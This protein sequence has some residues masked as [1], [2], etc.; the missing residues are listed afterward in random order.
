M[1]WYTTSIL[2]PIADSLTRPIIFYAGTV[3]LLTLI[4]ASL[5]LACLHVYSV[6]SSSFVLAIAAFA[7]S[8]WIAQASVWTVCEFSGGTL[9]TTD[10]I[11]IPQ[12]CPQFVFTDHGGNLSTG[13]T[14]FKDILAWI[15]VVAYLAMAVMACLSIRQEAQ[16]MR[17]DDFH[18]L[19]EIPP[20]FSAPIPPPKT[21]PRAR[22]YSST[23]QPVRAAKAPIVEI[24]TIP[25]QL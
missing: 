3:P 11:G 12:W 14:I 1:R 17:T 6:P 2:R 23:F 4:Q 8:A 5:H 19:V 20:K 25:N 21:V 9:T 16:G 13:L 22:P 7:F 24:R 10:K 18:E 15:L